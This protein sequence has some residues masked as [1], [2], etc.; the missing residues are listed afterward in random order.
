MLLR[1]ICTMLHDC[2]SS[3]VCIM[4]IWVAVGSVHASTCMVTGRE[5]NT[6]VPV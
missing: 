6:A 1:H 2:S 4:L 5:S 3:S